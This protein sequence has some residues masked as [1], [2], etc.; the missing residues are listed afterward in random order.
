MGRKEEGVHRNGC[1]QSEAELR[2]LQPVKGD[3]E[4]RDVQRL[5]GRLSGSQ[6]EP[7]GLLFQLKLF[8]SSSVQSAHSALTWQF[9]VTVIDIPVFQC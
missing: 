9:I 6:A 1:S 8:Q 5:C 3:A 7:G 4:P 2:P